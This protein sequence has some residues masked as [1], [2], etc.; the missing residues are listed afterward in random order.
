MPRVNAYPNDHARNKPRTST[1][2]SKSV[3]NTF[4]SVTV[5][6]VVGAGVVARAVVVDV[7][8][9]VGAVLL[10]HAL[11]TRPSGS[12]THGLSAACQQTPH[13]HTRAHT[14]HYPPAYSHS[15]EVG[16]KQL[17]AGVIVCK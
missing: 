14:Q 1:P 15:G 2:E 8:G 9:S 10:G 4:S 3:H 17:P 6:E 7:M 13:T 12:H 5:S 11:S 16:S